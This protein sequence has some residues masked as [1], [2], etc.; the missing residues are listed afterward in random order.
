[1]TISFKSYEVPEAVLLENATAGGGLQV[2]AA[3]EKYRHL[4]SVHGEQIFDSFHF[5]RYLVGLF[6]IFKLM[7]PLDKTWVY[8]NNY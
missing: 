3:T 1:M 6:S 8:W 7:N 4:K 5:D 2:T